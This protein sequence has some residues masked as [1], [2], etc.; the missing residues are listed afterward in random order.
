LIELE[1]YSRK[2]QTRFLSHPLRK[3]GGNVR[4]FFSENHVV[5]SLTQ[6]S[7]VT[8]RCV[9]IS[10]K[11]VQQDRHTTD[12]IMTIA[13]GGIVAMTC[14]K[15]GCHAWVSIPE[16]KIEWVIGSERGNDESGDLT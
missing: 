1:F 8:D 16:C 11:L 5:L 12:D 4:T 9:F 2:R 13:D 7:C 6:Y 15:S 14:E 3:L 10:L